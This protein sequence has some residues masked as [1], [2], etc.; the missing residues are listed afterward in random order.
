MSI[1]PEDVAASHKVLALSLS[2]ADSTQLPHVIWDRRHF[3]ADLEQK[4]ICCLS[5]AILSKRETRLRL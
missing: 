4:V 3:H 5:R 1:F 2:V